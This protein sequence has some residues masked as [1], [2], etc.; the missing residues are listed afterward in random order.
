[1]LNFIWTREPSEA[2]LNPYE[3]DAQE[4]FSREV[5]N[6]LMDLKNNMETYN[7]KFSRDET[8]V[9][10][11]I[12]ML[13]I[14]AID[15]LL[16]CHNLLTAKK[17]KVAGRLFR[18]TIEVLDLASFFSTKTD[19]SKSLL[20]KWFKDEVIP[21]REYR[22]YIKKHQG[23]QSAKKLA[24]F[25]SQLSKINHRTYRSLAYGYILGNNKMLVYDG[26]LKSDLL[27]FPGTISMYYSLL[28]NL[29][30]ILSREIVGGGLLTPETV[31][32][33]WG[34]NIEANPEE[35]KYFVRKHVPDEIR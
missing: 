23:E 25:Y 19:R 31:Q 1:M 18:D 10:K 2:Y 29:V 33:I 16:E 11:A 34:K 6:I 35:R 20:E 8:S 28:A 9:E 32:A 13:Q 30:I 24:S 22:D 3:Y 15:S 17:H 7:R 5:L 4:Q 26:F 21:N 27:V 12:W 14:D